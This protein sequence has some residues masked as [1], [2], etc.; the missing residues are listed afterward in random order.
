MATNRT[1]LLRHREDGHFEEARAAAVIS[2]G[3]QCAMNA[4]GTVSPAA[5]G[6]NPA[7]IAYEDRLQGK[8]VDDDY[9]IGDLVLLYYPTPGDHIHLL[10]TDEQNIAMGGGIAAAANGKFVA[11]AAGNDE[12]EARESLNLVGASGDQLIRAVKK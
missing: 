10:L 8:T 4:D 5:G 2:P 6:V 9:A 11:A 12:Y 1:I 3:M 7:L